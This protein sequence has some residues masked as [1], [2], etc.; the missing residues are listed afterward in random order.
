MGRIIKL[1][2]TVD[3]LLMA[4]AKKKEPFTDDEQTCI[5]AMQSRVAWKG[6]DLVDQRVTLTSAR[7]KYSKLMQEVRE[8]EN[9]Y[10]MLK[11]SE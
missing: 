2:T 5:N 9:D 8:L 6:Y 3:M 4:H 7:Q 10:P 1:E 11:G